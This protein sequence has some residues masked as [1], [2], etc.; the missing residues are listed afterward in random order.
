MDACFTTNLPP[1][2]NCNLY[3]VS[4]VNSQA[5][6]VEADN[7]GSKADFVLLTMSGHRELTCPLRE[8]VIGRGSNQR[9]V[10]Q[11]QVVLGGLRPSRGICRG[12][13]GDRLIGKNFSMAFEYRCWAVY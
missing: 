2:A 11:S 6:K 5:S 9:S 8:S 10:G 13:R 7:P 3:T 4:F 1:V 12:F